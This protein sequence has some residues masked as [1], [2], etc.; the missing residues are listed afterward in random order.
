MPTPAE[1]PSFDLIVIGAGINGA[2][3]AR[4]AS[5]LGR[6]VLLLDQSD[7]G[8]GT[9]AA[10]TRLIHGGLRYLQYAELNLVYESLGERER[11]L[12]TAPH[13]VTPLEFVLPVYAKGRRPLWQIRAGMML[14]DMLSIGKALPR[15]RMLGR[16]ELV[17]LMPGLEPAGLVGGASYYDAQATFPERLVIENVQDAVRNGATLMS[18]TT[19]TEI[20]LADGRVTGVRFRRANGSRGFARGAC[21]VNAS[22]PWVDRVLDVLG[23][24]HERLIGGT[25]GSHL[26]VEA[27][28]G[29]PRAAVYIEA[30]SD[31]RPFFVLPWNELYLIGTTDERFAGDPGD[32]AISEP[33]LDYLIRETESAFPGA[34]GLADRVLYTYSGV[35]PLPH[36]P[37]AAEGAI[38]RR[39]VIQ[40]HRDPRGLYSIVG[41]KLTTHRALAADV[42]RRIGWSGR[43]AHR[44]SP[45]AARSLPGGLAATHRDELLGRLESQFDASQARRLWGIYGAQAEPIAA[46]C[47]LDAELGMVIAPGSRTLVAE[48]VHAVESEWANHLTDILQR[49][50]MAGLGAD[51]GLRVAGPAAHWLVRLGIW[52]GARAATELADYRQCARRFRAR[53]ALG[54]RERDKLGG[55]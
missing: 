18:Y 34:R 36:S 28:P 55:R 21:V 51:F 15:H 53:E 9:S 25:R 4:E 44:A 3:I 24:G 26:V 11:L 29:A 49:R 12:K 42:I 1:A 27:F 31:G 38:T 20:L 5:L 48:L 45:T 33:E 50:C 23:R 16:D 2:A 8:S 10:S 22:G 7:V 46:R 40:A 43:F 37:D 6:S 17:R 30:A 47:R 39:H 13:L 52:D 41:G 32:V 19:V 54:V 35:R 14:Y